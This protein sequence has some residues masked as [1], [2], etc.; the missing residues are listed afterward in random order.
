MSTNFVEVVQIDYIKPHPNADRLDIAIIRGATVVVPKGKFT[1]Y[2]KVIYFPPDML[3]PELHANRLGVTQYLKHSTYP[4]DTRATQCR[5]GA[6]R[7]R[8][9]PSFGFIISLGEALAGG[10]A[11]SNLAV[12]TNVDR[13]FRA[14]KYEPPVKLGP[15]DSTREH[16]LFHRYTSIENFHRYPD[17]IPDGTPV[18]ITEKIHGTN[19]RVGLIREG[20]EWTFVAGS[21]RVQRKKPEEGQQSIYWEPLERESVL[22]LISHLCD[23]QHNVVVFGEIFG[24]GVQDMDYGREGRDYNVFDIT[25]DGRYLDWDE[26]ARVCDYFGVETVPLLYRGPFSKAVL[27]ECTDG[28]SLVGYH[29][30]S[31]KGRE[32]CVVTPLKETFYAPTGGRLILKSVS[33]DYLARKD[34]QDNE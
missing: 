33:V 18:R 21:H 11:A 7:L 27:A 22:N 5:V 32:G 4:G 6:V 23:E 1:R 13:Y 25:V 29:S 24:R 31:F 2:E 10:L 26:L 19:S 3:I 14:V 17:A 12:G 28:S 16:P 30:G 8:G 15:G 34:A 20:D 9:Q